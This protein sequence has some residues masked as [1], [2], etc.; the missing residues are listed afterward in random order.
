MAR[1]TAHHLSGYPDAAVDEIVAR[2]GG[3]MCG[4]VEA[5]LLVN[6]QLELK[7][8]GVHTAAAFGWRTERREKCK[9]Q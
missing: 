9:L 6:E 5:L 1:T 2:C 4:A 7:L 3:D 8:D